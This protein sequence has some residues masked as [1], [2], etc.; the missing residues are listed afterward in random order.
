MQRVAALF[1]AALLVATPRSVSAQESEGFV[2]GDADGDLVATVS[3]ASAILGHLFE[4]RTGAFCD[5]AGDANDDGFVDISDS[6]FLLRF[7]FL[8][9]R[10][11]PE[12]YPDAGFDSLTPSDL[13]CDA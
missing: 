11:P 13:P 10:T 6:V 5:D 8:E 4:N 3:D 9:G 12:P 7:L 1:W 2:R